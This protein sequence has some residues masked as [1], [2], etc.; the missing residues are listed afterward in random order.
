MRW[1]I[2][3]WIILMVLV[4]IY[5]GRRLIK[6]AKLKRYQRLLAW[7]VVIIIPLTQPLSFLIRQNAGEHLISDIISWISYIGFGF[8]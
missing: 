6:P 8:Y 1:F 7:A 3:V 4:Y 2:I 5:V